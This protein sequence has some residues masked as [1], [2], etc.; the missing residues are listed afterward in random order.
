M[1]SVTLSNKKLYHVKVKKGSNA[2]KVADLFCYENGLSNEVKTEL[3][4]LLV[5]CMRDY[6]NNNFGG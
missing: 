6:E 4:D 3:K 2:S 5:K 1:L